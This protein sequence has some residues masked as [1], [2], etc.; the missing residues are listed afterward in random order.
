MM[1]RSMISNIHT[2][3]KHIHT[4]Y[5]F[6]RR[7]FK[8]LVTTSCITVILYVYS[9]SSVIYGVVQRRTLEKEIMLLSSDIGTLEAEYLANTNTITYAGAVIL[10][11]TKPTTLYYESQERVALKDTTP[12]RNGF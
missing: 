6:E 5:V 7:F 9:L 10:G 8:I 12:H 1:I 4:Q 2:R 11:Y 3:K